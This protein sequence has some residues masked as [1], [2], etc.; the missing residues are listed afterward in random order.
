MANRLKVYEWFVK[1]KNLK[2]I[3][4]IIDSLNIQN[5]PIS[6]QE[7]DIKLVK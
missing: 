2:L 4:D 1:T 5:N 7:I 3:E 6:C